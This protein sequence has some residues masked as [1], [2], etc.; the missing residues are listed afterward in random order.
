MGYITE[1]QFKKLEERVN[2]I[3]KKIDSSP[4]PEKENEDSIWESISEFLQGSILQKA[5]VRKNDTTEEQF[6]KIML[7]LDNIYN[8]LKD[9]ISNAANIAPGISKKSEKGIAWD[10]ILKEKT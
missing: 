9:S 4:E 7:R 10:S 3:E 5:L 2:D 8:L 6:N 1:E